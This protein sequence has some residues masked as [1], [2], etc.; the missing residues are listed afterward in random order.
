MPA[1]QSGLPPPVGP[2]GLGTCLGP[3]PY[4]NHYP[5]PGP[6][7]YDFHPA[8]PSSVD[9]IGSP[10]PAPPLPFLAS[11]YPTSA[12]PAYSPSSAASA[13]AA[14]S[15]AGFG[16]LPPSYDDVMKLPKLEENQRF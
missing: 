2:A 5:T 8:G 6:N 16:D 10:P 4:P 12:P 1:G 7:P 9:G 14:A 13:S 15:A 11:P 3:N